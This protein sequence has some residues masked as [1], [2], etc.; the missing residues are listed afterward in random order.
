MTMLP[1]CAEKN[2]NLC[3]LSPTVDLTTNVCLQNPEK[4]TALLKN[5][6]HSWYKIS[7]N[8]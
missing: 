2:L 7:K 1:V 6:M 8:S 3:Y 5:N 4:V